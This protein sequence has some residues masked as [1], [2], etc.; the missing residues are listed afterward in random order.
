MQSSLVADT[1]VDGV[2]GGDKVDASVYT[3]S[4]LY[5]QAAPSEDSGEMTESTCTTTA[6]AYEFVQSTDRA[7]RIHYL[8]EQAGVGEDS[9]SGLRDCGF[10]AFRPRCLQR[11]ARI[12]VF[13]M[14]CCLLVTIQQTLSSGYLNSVITTI[15]KRFDIPSGL[16]GAIASTYELGN[17]ITIIFVSY[18]GSSRHIPVW[19]GRGVLLMG[20]GS[21]VFVVPHFTSRHYTTE[22]HMKDN[23]TD[24]NICR[25]A[26]ME[27]HH[28]SSF[29]SGD[30]TGGL[31]ETCIEGSNSNAISVF[32]FMIAQLMIGGGASPLFTLG[33]TYIDDHVKKDSAS[34]YIGCVYSMVAFGPV[35]GFLLGGFLL[36]FYVDSLTYDAEALNITPM[37]PRWVGAWWGGFLI[38]GVLL[39]IVAV[40][41]FAFPKSLHHEK[42]KVLLEEYLK[43]SAQ[44]PA[45]QL[46]PPRKKKASAGGTTSAADVPARR[47][48][49]DAGANSGYGRRIKDIPRS[50][51]RLLCNPIYITTC[52][53]SCMELMIVSGFI[54]FLPKYLET[55][56]SIGKSQANIFT[57]GIAI[58]GACIGVFM[59]G[60]ILKKLQLTPRGAIQFVMLFNAICLGLYAL[61]FLLGCD[62]VKMAGATMPYSESLNRP[63]ES[64]FEVNLTAGCNMVCECSPND[65]QPICGSNGITYF[66]PCHAGCTSLTTGSK[67]EEK[68]LS[69]FNCACILSNGTGEI[70]GREGEGATLGGF[71]QD[72]TVVPVATNGPCSNI[73]Q[74]IAPFM[75]LLFV[76]SLAV[77]MSQMPLFMIVLRSV[78]QEER[79]FALGMQFV[80]F[81]LFGYI[82][83]P[84]LF[85]NVIDSTCLLWKDHC[86]EPDARSHCL[87]YDIEK[88][89]FRYVGICTVIKVLAALLFLLDWCLIRR[90]H[91]D[92]SSAASAWTAPPNAMPLDEGVGD[93]D[94]DDAGRPLDK[95]EPEQCRLTATKPNGSAATDHNKT[96]Y[97]SAI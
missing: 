85:G 76:M 40:P 44:P 96:S 20:I 13:V 56:F 3:I 55:Q 9:D 51:W 97:E 42:R 64:D 72:V 61:V 34:M 16:S 23:D 32:I 63:L 80:I 15:E 53:G 67:A 87:M 48:P 57:G 41:F 90:R 17:L 21:L 6:S 28:G 27:S 58:P 45:L 36:S 73:C 60:Y 94:E 59:G 54:V 69:Y 19:L 8:M 24:R 33:T 14:L 10:C 86:A 71:H 2:G 89:R 95:M 35:C 11:F 74:T 93:D 22:E 5:S 39:L 12:K 29:L 66:S 4:G 7:E 79:S 18:L 30:G 92:P 47:Q 65:I 26:T 50:I 84:I 37:H 49:N 1:D 78:S 46:P 52:L 25:P 88:F 77:S 91:G 82:P 62:N 31:V 83:S 70:G 81:R 38:I 68:T 43:G 75:I